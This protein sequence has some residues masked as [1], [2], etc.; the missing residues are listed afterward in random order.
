MRP[1]SS[2]SAQGLRLPPCRRGKGLDFLPG[3]GRY[4]YL[5]SLLQ[6]TDFYLEV[7]AT[8]P[9]CPCCRGWISFLEVTAVPPC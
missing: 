6:R 4:P 5:L 3:G 1:G 9:C 2:H 8:P 7:A